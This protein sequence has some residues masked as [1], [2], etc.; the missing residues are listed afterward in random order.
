MDS[1]TEL[2]R[3]KSSMMLMG[4]QSSR[5]SS[6][7]IQTPQEADVDAEDSGKM[8]LI[9]FSY[10]LQFSC[11]IVIVCCV[12]SDIRQLMALSSAQCRHDSPPSVCIWV[13]SDYMRNRSGLSTGVDMHHSFLMQ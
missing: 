7:E 12:P 6:Q 1:M 8:W 10:N 2:E 3:K 9:I 11:S 13:G 4:L 5:K